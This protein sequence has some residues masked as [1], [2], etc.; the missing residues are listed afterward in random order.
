MKITINGQTKDLTNAQN[1]AELVSQFCKV[2]KNV[3]AE[4]NGGIVP[5]SDWA[6]TTLKDGDTIELVTF[7]GGG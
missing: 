4:I 3:I 2:P 1:I 5:S 7:V 6:K